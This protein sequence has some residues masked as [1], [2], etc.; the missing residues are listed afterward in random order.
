MKRCFNACGVRGFLPAFWLLLKETVLR[1]NY[2]QKAHEFM[3]LTL[4]Y[5]DSI[6][7][8]TTRG[9]E[10]TFHISATHVRHTHVNVTCHDVIHALTHIYTHT[11]TRTF[12]LIHT[13]ICYGCFDKIFLLQTLAPYQVQYFCQNSAMANNITQY[14]QYLLESYCVPVIDAERPKSRLKRWFSSRRYGMYQ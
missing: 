10:V 2:C 12:T 8:I 11:H 13:H 9:R 14:C 5:R 3:F 7:K 6:E 1:A 4:M